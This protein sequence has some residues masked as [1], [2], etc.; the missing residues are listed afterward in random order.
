M[1]VTFSQSFTT[2]PNVFGE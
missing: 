2:E 1:G